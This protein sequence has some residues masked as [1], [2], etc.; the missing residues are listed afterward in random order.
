MN[1]VYI[2]SMGIFGWIVSQT[3]EG[4]LVADEQNNHW[5]VE[6]SDLRKAENV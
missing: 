2:I 1:Y 5:L 3:S 6:V 4:M